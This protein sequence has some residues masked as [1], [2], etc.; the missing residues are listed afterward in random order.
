MP[1]AAVLALWGLVATPVVCGQTTAGYA[2]RP[3]VRIAQANASDPAAGFISGFGRAQVAGS[4]VVFVTLSGVQAGGVFRGRGGPLEVVAKPGSVLAGDTLQAFHDGFAQG[5][6]LSTSIAIAAGAGQADGVYG[7]DGVT[8]R[9]F[10]A[11]GTVLPNSGGLTANRIGEPHLVGEDLAVIA[12]HDRGGGLGVDFRGVYRV[13]DG[14]LVPLADTATALPGGWGVPEAFSSQLGFD[15]RMLAFWAGREPFAAV[16]GMFLQDAEGTLSVLARTGDAFTGGGVIDGFLSPPVVS[17]GVVYFFATAGPQHTRL[18]RFAGGVLT[19]LAKD[20]DPTPDG[21]V[22]Q[23]LGQLGLGVAE[24]RVFFPALGPAGAGV[25]VWEDGTLRTVI[26]AGAVVDGLRPQALVLQDVAGD[27]LVLEA[28]TATARRLVANLAAPAVPV[29]VSGPANQT[30]AGGARV[31]L[32]VTALGDGPLSYAWFRGTTPMVGAAGD[33]LV[34]E[35][36][37][38]TD[39]GYYR[40]RV[41]N[42]AGSAQSAEVLLNVDVAPVIVTPPGPVTLEAGDL[43][44]LRVQA[45]GGLPLVYRWFKD[46]VPATNDSP[47]FGFFARRVAALSDA[48]RYTVSVSNAQGEV[49]SAAVDVTILPPAPNPV[50]AGGRFVAVANGETPVPGTGETLAT[51]YLNEMA[52]A[53]WGSRIVLVGRTAGGASTGVLEREEGSWRVRLAPGMALP[54]GLGTAEDYQIV[55]GLPGEPLVIRALQNRDGFPQPVGFYRVDGTTV[56]S[57]ADLTTPVPGLEGIHLPN[58]FGEAIQAGGRLVFLLTSAGPVGVYEADGNG[59]RAVLGSGQELP[60][61]GADARQLQGLGFDG[62]RW[63]VVAAT[64]GLKSMVAL[65]G[66]GSEGVRPLIATGDAL[67]GTTSTVRSFGPSAVAE[68][69]V[70]L[71]LFDTGLAAHVVHWAEGVWTRVAGPGMALGDGGTLQAIESSS[72]R[73]LGNRVLLA[74]RLSTASGVRRG[75]LAAGPE[76]LESV[77]VAAKLDGRR[78]AGLG[79]ADVEA[80]RV[81]V[82]AWFEDGGRALLA[83]VGAPA[84]PVLRLDHERVGAVAVRLHVPEGNRLEAAT[85]LDGEWETVD[86]TTAV[87]VPLSGATRFFRLRGGVD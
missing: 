64:A 60:G 52:G 29:I 67:P 43:L 42:A 28:A 78:V 48:G 61:L 26:P 81:L 31:E 69:H 7:T 74:A 45:L 66:G 19:E 59:V 20:G 23:G 79:V 14:G 12:W 80:D 82:F 73:S 39:V 3:F 34:I 8:S 11:P 84:E 37:Q 16:Q 44:S 22:L 85:A 77:L 2:G 87:D 75:I 15:G 71:T 83:N 5:T 35:S 54:N 70:Y 40:V 76:G 13:S 4:A 86:A 56:V 25:Y 27:T 46:G 65:L 55:A 57:L 18:L 1:V 58:F 21:G 6:P 63:V 33:T 9:R 17:D 49:M 30:V 68:G 38:A 41:T 47:V 53:W 51:D 36:A 50:F 32:R 62:T 10:L 72:F 24:G